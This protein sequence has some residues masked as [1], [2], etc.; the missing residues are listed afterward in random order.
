MQNLNP[1]LV[2][3]VNSVMVH[4]KNCTVEELR[5]YFL[6]SGLTESFTNYILNHWQ[7]YATREAKS[8]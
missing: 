6:N 4:K 3:W 5:E 1:D 8:V 2:A 7:D